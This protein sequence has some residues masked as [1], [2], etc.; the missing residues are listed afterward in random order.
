ML[1]AKYDLNLYRG[2]TVRMRLSLWYDAGRTQP[3]DLDG[4]AVASQIRLRP[5]A[6]PIL[7]FIT[8]VTLPNIV[9]LLLLSTEARELPKKGV[10]DVQI[11]FAD[12]DVMSPIAG[13]M[14]MKP[15]VTLTNGG[16]PPPP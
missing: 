15:D 14:A 8:T 13:S 5:D 10:W 2:D 4:A 16:T 3:L 9:D 7:N 11:T 12:G 6:Q 1:P